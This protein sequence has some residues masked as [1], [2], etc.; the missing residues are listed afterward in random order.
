MDFI[1]VVVLSLAVCRITALLVYERG[2][3]SVFLR[4]RTWAGIEDYDQTG[5]AMLWKDGYFP[6]LLSCH[7]CASV[8]VAFGVVLIYALFDFAIIMFLPF[9]L[10][11]LSIYYERIIRG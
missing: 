1:H 5:D 7:W 6:E 4:I 2:P 8:M 11:A 9:A 3:W 10:S